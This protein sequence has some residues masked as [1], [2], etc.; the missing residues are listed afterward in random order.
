MINT[1]INHILL[2]LIYVITG[3]IIIAY[4][5]YIRLFITRLPKDLLFIF[6][7]ELNIKVIF[8]VLINIIIN[9]FIFRIILNFLFKIPEKESIIKNFFIKSFHL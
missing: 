3:S 1:K 9:L 6:E 2:S 7:G 4:M 8:I 5:L